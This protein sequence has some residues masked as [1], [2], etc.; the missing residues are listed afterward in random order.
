MRIEVPP[1]EVAAPPHS[2]AFETNRVPVLEPLD[3]LYERSTIWS[4]S[5][6]QVR[7]YAF[8]VRCRPKATQRDEG[9]ERG[10]KKEPIVLLGDVQGLRSEPV[11]GEKHLV[12]RMIPCRD[13]ER[14]SQ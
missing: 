3:A 8:G 14:P 12:R 13:H 9:R 5:L 11:D 2:A 7:N 10:C 6:D 4:Q 1:T